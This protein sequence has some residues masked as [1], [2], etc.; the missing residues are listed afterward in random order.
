LYF[1]FLRD[2]L[3]RDLT[4]LE[5]DDIR[6]NVVI[7]G[8]GG[9]IGYPFFSPSVER[10][11]GFASAVIGWGLGYNVHGETTADWQSHKNG[12]AL[13]GIRDYG[14]RQDWVPCPS[15]M[16]HFFDNPPTPL[17]EVVFYYH[18]DTYLEFKSLAGEVPSLNNC[19]VSIGEAVEFLASGSVVLT[20]TYHGAYWTALLGRKV[21]V[22]NPCSSR[23]YGMG[24]PVSFSSATDWKNH[25]PAASASSDFLRECRE[26]NVQFSTEVQKY[27]DGHG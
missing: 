15:C 14:E 6:G 1:P 12:Y 9:L 18:H 11:K 16:S 27:L 21:V 8:G 13:L 4:N 19:V 7:L 25:I 23:F 3:Q 10:I 26:R 22:L 24:F 5:V 17:R 20:T 2:A